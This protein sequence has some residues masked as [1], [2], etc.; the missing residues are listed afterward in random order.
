[1][2]KNEEGNYPLLI[3]VFYKKMEMVKLLIEY[4]NNVN[5]L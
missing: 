2:K 4:S 1:M 5:L 3:A